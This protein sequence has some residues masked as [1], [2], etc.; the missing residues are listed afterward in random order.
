MVS[1]ERGM[2]CPPSHVTLKAELA[3]GDAVMHGKQ[4]GHSARAEA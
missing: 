3:E 2:A 1:A 4:A